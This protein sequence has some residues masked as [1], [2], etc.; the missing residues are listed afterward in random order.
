MLNTASLAGLEFLERFHSYQLVEE[1]FRPLL[2]ERAK[3]A[4]E[5]ASKKHPRKPFAKHSAQSNLVLGPSL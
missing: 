1:D 4:A 3:K 2:T 5:K